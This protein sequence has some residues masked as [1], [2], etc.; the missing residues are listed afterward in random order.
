MAII[1][2]CDLQ[3]SDYSSA[4]SPLVSGSCI[5]W[6]CIA[7]GWGRRGGGWVG[8]ILQ[9]FPAGFLKMIWNSSM[10]YFALSVHVK[11]WKN[12]TH[13]PHTETLN[14]WVSE[15]VSDLMGYAIETRSRITMYL[16]KLQHTTNRVNI[17]TY[18]TYQCCHIQINPSLQ[19]TIDY[20]V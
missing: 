7:G 6:S 2:A 16:C 4:C 8:S 1:L 12:T 17:F 13:S 14:E 3:F 10:H 9:F 15:C 5:A 19:L 20:F 11:H 18:L